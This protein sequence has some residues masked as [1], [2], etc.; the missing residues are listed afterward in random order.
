[1]ILRVQFVCDLPELN[2]INSSRNIGAAFTHKM[3][4][5]TKQANLSCIAFNLCTLCYFKNL[6]FTW[7]C[8]KLL[9]HH[10]NINAQDRI[11]S[12]PLRMARV[13]ATATLSLRFPFRTI[14]WRDWVSIPE[15]CGLNRRTL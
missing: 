6:N 9:D 2:N 1:M 4:I 7:L 8:A 14:P 13:S 15:L 12:F 5:A 11:A 3:V 10:K